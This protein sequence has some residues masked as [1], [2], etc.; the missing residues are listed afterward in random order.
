[1]MERGLR[2]RRDL[3]CTGAENRMFNY[4]ESTRSEVLAA[5]H[6]IFDGALGA[7]PS[8]QRRLALGASGVRKGRVD[9]NR[10]A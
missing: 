1:M 10:C 2:A 9:V 5:R 3:A 7:F 8:V 6:G 4:D